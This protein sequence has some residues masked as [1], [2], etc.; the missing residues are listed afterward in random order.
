MHQ[1]GQEPGGKCLP[2]GSRKGFFTEGADGPFRWLFINEDY[3]KENKPATL[4]VRS[5][6]LLP[7]SL[8][9]GLGDWRTARPLQC[10]V[11]SARNWQSQ[12]ACAFKDNL[13]A[14]CGLVRVSG[15]NRARM[16]ASL[17]ADT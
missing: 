6:A 17:V 5:P 10:A 7:V 2:G 13:K 1:S 4:S 15:E 12:T 9:Y 14:C 11:Q 3:N 16:V 8:C